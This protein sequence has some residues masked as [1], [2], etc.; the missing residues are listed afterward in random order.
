MEEIEEDLVNK[1]LERISQNRQKDI[2]TRLLE[3]EKSMRERGEEEERKAEQAKAKKKTAPPALQQ[4]FK[5]KEKQIELLKTVPP[6]LS[7][8]Y[9][10]EV[11]EYFE[12][13]NKQ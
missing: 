8:Y 5:T 1:R 4:Y 11:D 12:K 10:K 9:K 2:E 3:S 13:I 6:A 7:P